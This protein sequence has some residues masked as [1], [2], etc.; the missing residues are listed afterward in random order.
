[1]NQ[2]KLGIVFMCLSLFSCG[3]TNHVSD[4]EDS[5]DIIKDDDEVTQDDGL[6][7]EGMPSAAFSACSPKNNILYDSPVNNNVS[8]VNRDNYGMG[9]WQ[10]VDA[11]SDEFDYAT[12]ETATDFTSKWKFGF[13][14]SYTGP[15]PTVWTGDQVSFETINGT[16]RALVL[17]A[18]E[19]GSG[20]S[21][22]LK[23]GM[24]TSKAKSS[25][26]LFQ[27]AKVK[28]SNSQLAN[29]VWMLSDDPGT[30]EEIDN[31][32]AYGPKVRPDGTS[33]DF[34]YY[35][36]RIHLSHHT[37]KNDG[38]QRLDYQPHQQTWMSRKKTTGDCSRD[39]EVVW[40][41][42]YHYFGVKWVSETRLEYFVDGKRVKV[43]D[44]LRV[45]DG[46]DPH[47]YTS[48]GDGLTREMHMIISHAAQTWRYPSVDAFWNSSD[49]KTGEH[50][51]MRVDWIRVYSPDGN[52]NTRSCN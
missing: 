40:S 50:T 7:K 2:I 6:D 19:T 48:C 28:I 44:G 13:V 30:T 42:D 36:D 22:R 18:A 49:I 17:Q 24:I 27:E 51:K 14:N 20:A 31:V 29:A 46:I 35:A 15:V 43:V 37:F 39:N 21:R 9:S 45:D 32:E 23:C 38:G 33:C 8:A 34:P 47:S 25:Y 1:M 5:D 26:P 12:G 52:V 4:I 16:N 41:E 11:L 10:L 3:Q